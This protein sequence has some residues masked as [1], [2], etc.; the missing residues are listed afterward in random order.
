ML[1]AHFLCTGLLQVSLRLLLEYAADNPHKQLLLLTPQDMAAVEKAKQAV[2]SEKQFSDKFVKVFLMQR[3][4]RTV[5]A[6]AL[7][8]QS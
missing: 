1:A 2:Q 3:A 4:T 5:P 6:A 8:T 7:A